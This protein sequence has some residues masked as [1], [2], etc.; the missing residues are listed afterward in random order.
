MHQAD[1]FWLSRPKLLVNFMQVI[2]FTSAL[3]LSVMSQLGASTA[4]FVVIIVL[5]STAA[6]ILLFHQVCT[7]IS[8]LSAYVGPVCVTHISH[9]RHDRFSS[10]TTPAVCGTLD[11]RAEL[12]F[13]CCLSCQIVLDSRR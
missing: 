7:L 13:I 11:E 8:A 6:L 2:V 3:N 1:L 5:L 4:W 9:D 12:R 10:V